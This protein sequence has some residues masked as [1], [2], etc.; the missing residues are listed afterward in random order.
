V[1]KKIRIPIEDYERLERIA[2]KMN[3]TPDEAFEEIMLEKLKELEA[4]GLSHV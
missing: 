2:S 3:K 4:G 1:R